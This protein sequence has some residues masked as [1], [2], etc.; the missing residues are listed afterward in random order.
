MKLPENGTF[1]EEEKQLEKSNC[2]MPAGKGR[3]DLRTDD[4]ES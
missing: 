4:S 3:N 2:R 1:Q